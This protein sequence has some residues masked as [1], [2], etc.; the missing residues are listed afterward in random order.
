[1]TCKI[2]SV[3]ALALA[4]A[5]SPVSAQDP[6][7]GQH[8]RGAAVMGFDQEKTAHHFYLY[9]DGGAIDVAVKNP[10]DTANRDAIRSHL[11]HIATLFGQG[12]FTAPMLVHDSANVPGI[13]EMAK[14]QDK[15]I[16]TYAETVGGGRVDIKTTDASALKAVHEFLKFQ[17][18]DHKTGDTLDVRKR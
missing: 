18:S 7:A 13:V 5:V 11:P 6:H 17:I 16:Y 2:S 1:M 10:G 12:N 9:E 14:L 15:I 3:A 8:Q 4:L